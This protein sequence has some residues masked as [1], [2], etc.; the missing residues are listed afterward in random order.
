MVCGPRR[1]GRRRAGVGMVF[2]GVVSAETE[3]VIE[4][5]LAPEEAEG[6]IAE[7]EGDEPET[8]AWLRVESVEFEHSVN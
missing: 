5:F 6:F 2:Y 4:F 7:V 3:R 1:P 8:A